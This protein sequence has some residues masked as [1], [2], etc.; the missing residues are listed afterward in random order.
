[1]LSFRSPNFPIPKRDVSEQPRVEGARPLE[2]ILQEWYRY[3]PDAR[4]SVPSSSHDRYQLGLALDHGGRYQY[5]GG[6]IQIP[7][8]S[9]I[10]LHPGEPHAAYDNHP[11]GHSRR[12]LMMY[13]DPGL[14]TSWVGTGH[15]EPYV[16]PVVT[17]ESLARRYIRLFDRR[18][19]EGRW[20]SGLTLLLGEL[21]RR[22]SRHRLAPASHGRFIAERA[23]DYIRGTFPARF[24][25]QALGELEGVSRYTVLRAFKARFEMTPH[26]YFRSLQIDSVKNGLVRGVPLARLAF[27]S[28]FVDQAH[29]TKVFSL[30]V[31]TTPGRYVIQ[32]V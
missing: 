2:G 13:L 19:S 11:P 4:I 21:A 29:M 14:F 1:M 17:D 28:G 25:L 27:D 32:R 24:T 22:H 12:Y 10:V 7:V 3:E 26:Q 8:G 6:A 5:R 30:Y 20:E 9:I 16:P 23:R 15:T 18:G 31:G